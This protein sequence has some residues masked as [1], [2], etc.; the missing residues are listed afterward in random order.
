MRLLNVTYR[1]FD[2]SY[3][4]N[5][6][7]GERVTRRSGVPGPMTNSSVGLRSLE[8]SSA[9]RAPSGAITGVCTPSSEV[10]CVTA[11]PRSDT[12]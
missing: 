2:Q 4:S 3:C 10:T 1:G 5:S 11:P 7:D 8:W 6:F 9:I 12:R